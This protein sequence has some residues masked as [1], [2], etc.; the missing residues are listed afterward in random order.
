MTLL[1]TIGYSF[2]VGVAVPVTLYYFVPGATE[3]LFRYLLSTL[4]LILLMYGVQSLKT[5]I[6]KT[7]R[8]PEAIH[9]E[10]RMKGNE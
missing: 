7:Q 5:G 9:F 10:D 2:Y 4:L 6:S 1:K 8:D 3:S